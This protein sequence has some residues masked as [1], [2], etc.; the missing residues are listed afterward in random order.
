[1]ESCNEC[2]ENPNVLNPKEI[3]FFIESS[4][5]IEA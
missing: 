4:A 2:S 3:A 5:V 1:M